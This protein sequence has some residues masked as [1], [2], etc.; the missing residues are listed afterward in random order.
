MSGA[1]SVVLCG[2]VAVLVGCCSG[3]Q[4]GCRG[5]ACGECPPA[6]TVLLIDPDTG[7]EIGWDAV[8]P[9]AS[10]VGEEGTCNT[11]GECNVPAKNDSP[12]TEYKF[13]VIFEGEIVESIVTT[14]EQKPAAECC[15]C[16]YATR[17]IR[18]E[19]EV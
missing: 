10:I 8:V 7:R 11:F 3:T 5:I 16:G 18:I 13:D 6:V 9:A 14:A 2:L 17:I 12:A 1:L 15:N 4:S 19:V